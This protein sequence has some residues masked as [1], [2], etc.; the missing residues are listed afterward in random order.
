MGKLARRVANL[1]RCNLFFTVRHTIFL[2][3][4]ARVCGGG[5][6]AIF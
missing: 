1:K 4:K 5:K 6:V 2:L 3:L